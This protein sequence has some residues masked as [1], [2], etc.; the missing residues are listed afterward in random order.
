MASA[1][2]A[3]KVHSK[4]QMRA[5]GL[6]S[7]S[8]VSHFSQIDRISSGMFVILSGVLPPPRRAL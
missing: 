2:S 3:Q 7:A 1:Q 5:L 8:A 4:E 6:S